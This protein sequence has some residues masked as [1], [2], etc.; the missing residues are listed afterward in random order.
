MH[1]M[2]LQTGKTIVLTPK[3]GMQDSILQQRWNRVLPWAFFPLYFSMAD[4]EKNQPSDTLHTIS[5]GISFAAAL[6][7]H[8]MPLKPCKLSFPFLQIVHMHPSA[9]KYSQ[10]NTT[11]FQSQGPAHRGCTTHPFLRSE[12]ELQWLFA[13]GNHPTRV[14]ASAWHETW[15]HHLHPTL[16]PWSGQRNYGTHCKQEKT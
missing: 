2:F 14:S 5:T 4:R 15:C 7:Q 11:C 10:T 12:C 3:K 8:H 9:L 13:P 1:L 16:A 6:Q